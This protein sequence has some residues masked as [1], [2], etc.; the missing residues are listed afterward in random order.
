MSLI[1]EDSPLYKHITLG[2]F[3]EGVKSFHNP[4]PTII[5]IGKREDEK[6]SVVAYTYSDDAMPLFPTVYF[7]DIE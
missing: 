2:N 1:P 3:K 5:N 6:M 4:V 7:Y